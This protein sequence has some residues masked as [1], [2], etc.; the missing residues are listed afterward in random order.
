MSGCGAPGGGAA[1]AP[2]AAQT[3]AGQTAENTP[4]ADAVTVEITPPAGWESVAGSVLDVQY[5]KGTASFLV[6]PEEL[7][8]ATLDE[9]VESAEAIY[10]NAF[11]QY[12][13]EGEP[14]TITIDGKD[15]RRL[16]FTCT[17]S[18]IPM[19]FVYAYLFAGNQTYV[20]TFGDQESTF[21]AIE[22]DIDAILGSIRFIEN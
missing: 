16:T 7:A 14:E 17:V 18:N 21:D 6:K 12:A 11:G 9:A 1:S 13:A 3:S 20:I 10:Q 8:G 22:P 2:P 4:P 5:L 19:K 15:A